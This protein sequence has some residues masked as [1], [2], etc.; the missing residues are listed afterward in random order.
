MSHPN[1]A[2]AWKRLLGI[3][4]LLATALIF[5]A[6][7]WPF[8]PKPENRARWIPDSK[9]I[10]FRRRGMLTSSAPLAGISEAADA[11][12]TIELVLEATRSDALGLI[13]GFY[14]P[15]LPGNF[16]VRQYGDGILLFRNFH[17]AE[18]R[19]R[20]AEM[21]VDHVLPKGQQVVITLTSGPKGTVAYLN[22][23]R[24]EG[25]GVYHFCGNLTGDL[26]LGSSPVEYDPSS[27]KIFGLAFYDK[28]LTPAEILENAGRWKDG[29][30]AGWS[31]A[32]V[33]G[34]YLFRER[35]GREITEQAG[36]LP[37]LLIPEHFGIPHKRWFRPF[38]KEYFPTHEY[39]MDVLRNI[40]GFIPLGF[41]F[42][43]YFRIGRASGKAAGISIALG[44][45]TSFTVEFLQYFVPQR[46]SGTTDI[47]TNTLGTAIGAGMAS[48]P[49]VQRMI[50]RIAEIFARGSGVRESE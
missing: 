32:G 37:P 23:K 15:E 38:W 45:L 21:D 19:L 9:G 3:T 13:L 30:F 31:R 46:E 18:G 44:A 34:R 16:Q 22:G 1:S 20:R 40:L 33:V 5:A 7:L 14:T 10:E 2:R 35:Q 47:I 36:A 39:A 17:D 27:A 29:E 11:A 43:T 28:V 42:F 4:S 6:T 49:A 50:L 8:N 25:Y 48:L 26:I 41:I 24:V 12:C